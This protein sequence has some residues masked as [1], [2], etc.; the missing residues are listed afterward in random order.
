LK[1]Y[2]PTRGAIYPNPPT[3]TK[4]DNNTTNNKN[5]HNAITSAMVASL[6]TEEKEKYI[7]LIKERNRSC[8]MNGES[9]LEKFF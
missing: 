5:N 6:S 8:T 4:T 3:F 7:V 9:I 1:Y 2:D